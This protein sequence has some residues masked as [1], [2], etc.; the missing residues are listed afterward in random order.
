MMSDKLFSDKIMAMVGRDVFL[1]T[2][3]MAAILF[4]MAAIF[5]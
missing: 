5:S 4:K 1:L 2:Q 3:E